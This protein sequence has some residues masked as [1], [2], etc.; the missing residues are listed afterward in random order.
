MQQCKQHASNHPVGE[1]MLLIRMP[2]AAPVRHHL[3]RF[4]K[5]NCFT[6]RHCKCCISVVLTVRATHTP[7]TLAGKCNDDDD[8]DDDDNDNDND[9]YYYYYCHL[10]RLSEQAAAQT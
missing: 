9:D 4:D 8:D 3:T 2:A 10:P 1:I 5:K 7:S 6:Q